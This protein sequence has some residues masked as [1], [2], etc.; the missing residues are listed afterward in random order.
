MVPIRTQA[1]VGQMRHRTTQ[2]NWVPVNLAVRLV[3]PHTGWLNWTSLATSPPWLWLTLPSSTS[4]VATW[5]TT[6]PCWC[7]SCCS[8][9]CYRTSRR[10]RLSCYSH[11]QVI[12]PQPPP[13]I[14][15]IGGWVPCIKQSL[16]RE[17]D[18]GGVT[19]VNVLPPNDHIFDGAGLLFWGRFLLRGRLLSLRL[20]S[21]TSET[22]PKPTTALTTHHACVSNDALGTHVLLLP[23]T[24]FELSKTRDFPVSRSKRCKG[25]QHIVKICIYWGAW[26]GLWGTFPLL[27]LREWRNHRLKYES[28]CLLTGISITIWIVEVFARD[29]SLWAFVIHTAIQP[30]IS[31]PE[32]VFNPAVSLIWKSETFT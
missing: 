12:A 26:W 3:Q 27:V 2:T 10:C 11:C 13:V 21:K 24:F 5:M 14:S 25:D 15:D 18:T 9:S 4:C 20:R 7:C 23:C 32:Q 1:K 19:E 22:W 31:F 29:C 8:S 30:K 16:R 6:W 28:D 17:V